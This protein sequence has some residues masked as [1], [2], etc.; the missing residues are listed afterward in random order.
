MDCKHLPVVSVMFGVALLLTNP[1]LFA[2]ILPPGAGWSAQSG[3]PDIDDSDTG[4][5]QRLHTVMETEQQQMQSQMNLWF[6]PEVQESGAPD[7][8][9]N[10]VSVRELQ[11]PLSRKG[12]KL[13]EKVESYLQIGQ[14]AKAKQELAEA[15]KE[16]SAAPYAHAILG[17]EYLKEGKPAAAIPELEDAARVLSTAGIHSNLGYAL[18]LTGQGNRGAQE[19]EEALRLDGDTVQARFLLGVLLLNQKSREQEARYELNLAQRRMRSAHLALAVYH[20]RRG[21]KDA[22]EEQV[23]EYLGQS[24]AANF[25][26]VWQWVCDAADRPHPAEAFGFKDARADY[27]SESAGFATNR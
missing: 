14:N 1:M 17:T 12:R 21:E 24:R 20:V 27:S 5:G 3:P 26:S 13:I 19:F 6:M 22:A 11:H 4:P 23:Q 15:F 16:P 2:Q 7:A 25:P 18:C 8:G 9:H 10:T